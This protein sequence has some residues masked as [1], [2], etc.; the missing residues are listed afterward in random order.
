M[1]NQLDRRD[2]HNTT[3]NG[4]K[5]WLKVMCQ[6]VSGRFEGR[7]GEKVALEVT[8]KTSKEDFIQG[9]TDGESMFPTFVSC[10]VARKI[11]EGTANNEAGQKN[12]FVDI[13]IVAA[14][15]QEPTM[16]RTTTVKQLVPVMRSLTTMSTATLAAALSML[17][18][19]NAYPLSVQYPVP[20]L[21][22]QLCHKV[23]ILIRATKKSK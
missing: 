13:T 10:K 23:W 15:A 8:G 1:A 4:E 21:D 18:S 12:S 9:A 6:D 14:C 5:L 16:P 20:D 19:T 17:R 22:P 11:K 7:M 2:S 3:D